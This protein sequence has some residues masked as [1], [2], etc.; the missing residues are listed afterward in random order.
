M[1]LALPMPSWLRRSADGR[2]TGLDVARGLALLGMM[3]AHILPHSVASGVGWQQRLV[4]G[5]SAALFAILA[6]VTMS[7]LSGRDTPATGRRR[8]KSTIALVIRAGLIVIWGLALDRLETGGEGIGVILPYYG[9]LF[10]LGIPFLGLRSRALFLWAAVWAMT[11]PVLSHVFRGQFPSTSGGGFGGLSV[12][13]I[14]ERLLLTG[15]YPAFT[16]LA[17]LLC[18]MAIGRLALTRRDIAVRLAVA[19]AVLAVTADALSACLTG[20]SAARS[21]L[22]SDP[23]SPGAR[24]W[25]Q[26]STTLAEGLSG[27]TPT[28]TYW[29]LA[30]DAPH[31][32]A[33]LDLLRSGGLAVAVIGIALLL[34]RR[35]ARGWEIVFG[36]GAMTLTLY[37]L[38]L[39]MLL[40]GTWPDFGPPRWTPEVLVVTVIGMFFAVLRL[41]GP[42]EAVVAITC[43]L[44]AR[45]LLDWWDVLSAKFGRRGL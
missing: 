7:L 23:P 4:I 5:N 40:P 45:L 3:T 30:V 32:G 13:G 43:R 25:H 11:A 19:G 44:S 16:W 18:G 2:Y 39:V 41:K 9:V 27:I 6:G 37:S 42:L 15:D 36:A 35:F 34:T 8:T 38:H 20:S 14:G 28:G 31:S 22:L 21:A 29:W 10:L 33:S 1:G 24:D 26:L 12:G 17:Y